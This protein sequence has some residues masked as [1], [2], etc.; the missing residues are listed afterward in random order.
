LVALALI[1]IFPPAVRAGGELATATVYP[2]GVDLQARRQYS[3]AF[4]TVS[5]G[6]L[7]MQ[8]VFE[9]GDDLSIG[10][11]DLE[12][13]LLLDGSY[14]WRL[15]L[16]PDAATARRLRASAARNDG[17]APDAWVAE[18]GTFAISDGRMVPP[19]LQELGDVRFRPGLE[20][21]STVGS[22]PSSEP[23]R[24]GPVEDD[25]AAVGS[26]LGVEEEMRAALSAAAT[27]SAGV[28]VG[29]K[30]FERSD[31]AALALGRS[32]EPPLDLMI[33]NRLPGAASPAPRSIS[34]DG[35]D[36]RPT[37]DQA[38]ERRQ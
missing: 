22:G 34:P 24:S 35:K 6:D 5:G 9:P 7:V 18:T 38:R 20:A 26:R 27:P 2:D 37:R 10:L 21:G 1:A 11:F 17:V 3:R 4:L 23:A 19:D 25:D 33:H 15:E 32:L 12:G 16:V 14:N 36:G 29:H 8:R 28:P 13:Q 31:A 30:N